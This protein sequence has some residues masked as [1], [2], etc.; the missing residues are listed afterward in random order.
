MKLRLGPRADLIVEDVVVDGSAAAGVFVAGARGFRLEDAAVRSTRADGIHITA[1]STDGTVVRPE[2]VGSGDDGVAVVSYGSDEDPVRRVVVQSPRVLDTTWGRGISVVGGT[3]I[4][5]AD[6]YV[7]RTDSAGVYIATGGG[8]LLH[9]V[10]EPG[11]RRGWR[12]VRG[13]Q[14]RGRRPRR[15]ASV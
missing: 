10:D 14:Q 1:G 9:H 12:R 7:E 15:S 5:Y 11:P 3:D 6:I 13:E 4:T 2:V 8:A